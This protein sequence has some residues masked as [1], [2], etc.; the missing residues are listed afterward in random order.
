MILEKTGL[1]ILRESGLDAVFHKQQ[2]LALPYAQI[3]EVHVQMGSLLN[4]FISIAV[5][6]AICPSNVAQAM[7]DEYSVVF[8]CFKNSAAETFARELRKQLHT[9]RFAQKAK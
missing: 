6:G 4:G 3:N 8:R 2:R 5:Q 9:A 7:R 1:V